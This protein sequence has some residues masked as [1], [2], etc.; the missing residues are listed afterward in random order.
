[1]KYGF[2]FV[3]FGS[4][5]AYTSEK[6]KL[7]VFDFLGKTKSAPSVWGDKLFFHVGKLTNFEILWI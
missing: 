4:K 6:V 5:V 2:L 7:I 3:S 1:M